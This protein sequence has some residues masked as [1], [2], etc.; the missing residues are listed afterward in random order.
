VRNFITT[1]MVSQG[2]P[3]L[4]GG[5][6]LLRTQHGNNNAYCQDNEISWFDWNLDERKKAHLEFVAR[7]IQLRHREPVLRR[8]KFFSGGYVHDSDRKDIGWFRPDGEE[9]TPHDWSLPFVRALGM[10]LGGDAIPTPDRFGERIRGD[11]LLVLMNAH[12]EAIEFVLPPVEWGES[13][14]LLIDTTT[15]EAPAPHAASLAREKYRV[16]ARAMVVLKLVMK[17]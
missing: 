16:E 15:C 4:C 8:R 9:M 7:V 3:M 1:L 5:D 14:E 6:E 2:V 10:L 11:S 12:H 13:W 17:G